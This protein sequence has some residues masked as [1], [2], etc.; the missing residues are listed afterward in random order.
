[1]GTT[2]NSHSLNIW[3]ERFGFIFAY[4]F[5]SWTGLS[6]QQDLDITIRTRLR[7]TVWIYFELVFFLCLT[8]IDWEHALLWCVCVCVLFFI[9]CGSFLEIRCAGYGHISP[10]ERGETQ[11]VYPTKWIPFM[12]R[13]RL[14][15]P[16]HLRRCTN[17]LSRPNWSTMEIFLGL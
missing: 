2:T 11:H 8:T 9:L 4:T 15:R 12:Y 13:V 5:S 17:R 16:R 3:H 7:Q 1:M 10:W 14:E 6:S